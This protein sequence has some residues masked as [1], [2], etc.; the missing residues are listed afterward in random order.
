M[1]NS[2][3]HFIEIFERNIQRSQFAKNLIIL[4][5]EEY[6]SL[7]HSIHQELAPSFNISI[8]K[9]NSIFDVNLENYILEKDIFLLFYTMPWQA[10]KEYLT[11][12]RPILTKY[13]QR[14]YIV[15]DC[16][17]DFAKIYQ[18]SF[19]DIT[20]HHAQL[21]KLGATTREVMINNHLGTDLIFR[22]A[23]NTCWRQ[24]D[25]TN[26]PGEIVPAEISNYTPDVN[27]RVVFTGALVSLMPIGKKYG[28]IKDPITMDIKNGFIETIDCENKNLE[29]DL[30]TIFDYTKGNRE[31]VELGIGTNSAI[32]LKG[33]SA[34]FEER[35]A[36]FH[37]GTGGY[38]AKTQHID[39]VFADSEIYFDGVRIMSPG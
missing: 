12:V 16:L 7:A 36:G 34:P 2:L 13:N 3:N 22:F 19:A 23:A 15:R 8:K 11:N 32:Q 33:I 1:Q 18:T 26:I 30:L 5:T 9:L 39:F 27:G 28:H 38:Q 4:Y 24:I 21:M 37:L 14:A 29:N 35:K 6:Q 17:D 20:E 10:L 25:G 31:I